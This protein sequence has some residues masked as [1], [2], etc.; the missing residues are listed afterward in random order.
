MQNM[1][2]STSNI[3]KCLRPKINNYAGKPTLKYSET[4]LYYLGQKIHVRVLIFHAC[5]SMSESV[6]AH[7]IQYPQ[8]NRRGRKPV[9]WGSLEKNKMPKLF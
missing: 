8:I 7:A 4:E 3:K 2:L 1:P 6:S 9:S 5:H